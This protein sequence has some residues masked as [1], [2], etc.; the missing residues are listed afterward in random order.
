MIL[1]LRKALTLQIISNNLH[2]LIATRLQY[3]NIAKTDF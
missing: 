2:S 1:T 3:Y